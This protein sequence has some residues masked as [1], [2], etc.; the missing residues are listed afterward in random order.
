[1][2]PGKNSEAIGKTQAENRVLPLGTTVTYAGWLA[3]A[4]SMNVASSLI[5]EFEAK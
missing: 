4:G 3:K 1:M 2:L 5:I